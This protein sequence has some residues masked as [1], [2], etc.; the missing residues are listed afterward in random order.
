MVMASPDMR[1]NYRRYYELLSFDI[2]YNLLKMFTSDGKR[3][4]LGVFC[5]TDTNI[6]ILLAGIAIISEERIQDMYKMFSFFFRIH[7]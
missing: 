6:R 5:V 4:R 1:R 2:T 7:G 3:F